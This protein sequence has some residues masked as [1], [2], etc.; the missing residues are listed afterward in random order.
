M[1]TDPTEPKHGEKRN[2]RMESDRP[3][4]TEFEGG[5]TVSVA[6]DYSVVEQYCGNCRKWI[7]VKG[8]FD[9][10]RFMGT[11]DVGDCDGLEKKS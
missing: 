2:W 6:G 11:H 3:Q 7:T 1:A 4:T 9:A 8:V 10:I 5:L